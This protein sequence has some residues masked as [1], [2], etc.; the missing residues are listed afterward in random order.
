MEE[1]LMENVPWFVGGGA[2]HSPEVARLLAYAGTGGAGGIAEPGGLKVA[3]LSV[4]GTSVRVLPG[5]AVLVNQYPGGSQQSYLVRSSVAEE[6]PVTAT[7]SGSGRN[8]LVVARVLDPQYEGSAPANPDTFAYARVARIQGVSAANVASVAAAQ[9]YC[10]TLPYPCEP[11]AAL[12]LPAST[13]TVTSGMIRDLRQLAQARTARAV[14]TGQPTAQQDLTASTFTIFPA[15]PQFPVEIPLWATYVTVIA[16]LSG[17]NAVNAAAAGNLRVALGS[18]TSPH[19]QWDTAAD[20]TAMD[21]NSLTAVMAFQAPI[22]AG[23]AGRTHNCR[24]EGQR[25]AGT[26]ALRAL[27]GRTT[28]TL[29]L[30]FEQ[31]AV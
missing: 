8:D 4:P 28:F 17:I 10:Q 27:T 2:Q 12:I 21:P 6:V 16:T 29:D 13:G 14:F 15:A 18:M 9:A 23:M 11:L 22:N 30:T 31:R 1:P 7:G 24:I 26:G 19:T 20:T 3:P 5:A 25:V